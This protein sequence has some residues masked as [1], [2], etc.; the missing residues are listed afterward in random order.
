MLPTNTLNN[1]TNISA[2]QSHAVRNRLMCLACM[3]PLSNFTN[4]I[5][6]QCRCVMGLAFWSDA[7]NTF[8]G[9]ESITSLVPIFLKRLLAGRANFGRQFTVFIWIVHRAMPWTRGQFQVANRVIQFV[10]ICVVNYFSVCKWSPKKLTHNESML[11]NVSRTPRIGMVWSHYKP[12][13]IFHTFAVVPVLVARPA[14]FVAFYVANRI[15][16]LNTPKRSLTWLKGLTAATS[17]RNHGANS[18]IGHTEET[19]LAF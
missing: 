13:A 5:F 9:A 8:T 6:C 16:A 10:L 19:W 11:K 4:F 17:T 3:S 14:L 2:T 1:S 18:N 15:A 7:L 12:I